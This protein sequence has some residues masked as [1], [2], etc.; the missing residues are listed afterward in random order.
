MLVHCL[1]F[2]GFFKAYASGRPWILRAGSMLAVLG[3]LA[4]TLIYVKNVFLVFEW[5]V[6]PLFFANHYFDAVVPLMSSLFYLFF[7]AGFKRVQSEKEHAILNRSILSA[8][9]G[10]LIFGALHLIVLINFLKFQ[11][12]NWLAHMPRLVAVLIVPLTVAAAVLILFF[13][14]RFYQFLVLQQNRGSR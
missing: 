8:I 4:V 6:F 5:N 9:V 10:T 14:I 13:Y 2:V 12:F 3:S 7:F 11:K 1:F